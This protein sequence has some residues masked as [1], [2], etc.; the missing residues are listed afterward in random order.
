MFTFTNSVGPGGLEA[1]LEGTVPQ[2]VAQIHA[3]AAARKYGDA[4]EMIARF[5]QIA[6]EEVRVAK[7]AG[8]E[9]GRYEANSFNGGH[10]HC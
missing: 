7:Q 8:V 9:S 4:S 5:M 3:K 10:V 2:S 6:E 1:A